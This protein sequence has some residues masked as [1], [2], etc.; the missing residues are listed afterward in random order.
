ML[1]NCLIWINHNPGCI[2][3][4]WCLTSPA[5]S[6]SHSQDENEDDRTHFSPSLLCC[7]GGIKVSHSHSQKIR[8]IPPFIMLTHLP[9][10]MLTQKHSN[11]STTTNSF[12][13]STISISIFLISSSG[14]PKSFQIHQAIWTNIYFR[15]F[16]P[17]SPSLSPLSCPSPQLNS[18]NSSNSKS[19]LKCLQL[20]QLKA[21]SLKPQFMI[22]DKIFSSSS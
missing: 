22:I 2:K 18:S 13:I 16:S 4:S 7:S 8:S 11:S 20:L 3:L 10:K 15:H 5:V 14:S 12:T 17:L 21:H 19:N 1:S 9:L 6:H